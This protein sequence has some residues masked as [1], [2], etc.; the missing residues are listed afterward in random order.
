MSDDAQLRAILANIADGVNIV[1]PDARIVLANQGFLTMY[2]FPSALGATGTPLAEFVRHRLRRQEHYAGENPA[3]PE[4]ALV[5]ARVAAIMSAP[6]G[7]FEE[8]RPDGRTI[9]VRRERLPDGTL[10]N[11]YRETTTEREAAR[12]RRASRE[13]LRRNEHLSAVASLLA[14]VAHEINNPLAVVAA[15]ALLLAEDAEGTPLAVRADKVRLAAERCGRIVASLLATARQKPPRREH[16]AMAEAIAAGLDLAGV[17]HLRPEIA[18]DLPPIRGDADQLAHL[19]ANLVTNARA[20]LVEVSQ[21]MIRVLLTQHDQTLLLRV[22]DN[23]PG[24]P[25]DL[26]E[27]VFAAFYTTKPDGEGT[28]V[29]LALCRTIV[30]AHGGS[31]TVDDTPGGGATFT[32]R[33]PLP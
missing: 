5:Q 26:R 20:A 1:G 30:R 24:I 19:V 8:A 7:R 31:I 13:A 9:A 29:G 16:V 18:P 25:A 4:D 17:P 10:L 15:Q 33:L 21:P 6:A 23:G 32:V 2:D 11:T 14:G 27:R 3:E 22:A 28:G 12:A